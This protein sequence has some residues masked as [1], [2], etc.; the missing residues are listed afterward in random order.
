MFQVPQS[1]STI[2]RSVVLALKV[3]IS[4]SSTSSLGGLEYSLTV[5]GGTG[6]KYRTLLGSIG[7]HIGVPIFGF[8]GWQ[9]C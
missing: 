1:G 3:Q 8:Q 2:L 5:A 9:V 6:A 4:M 7:V